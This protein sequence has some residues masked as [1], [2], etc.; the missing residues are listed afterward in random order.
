MINNFVILF[1]LSTMLQFFGCLGVFLLGIILIAVAFLG[2]LIDSIL[3]FLG[4]KKRGS[5][6]SSGFGYGPAGYGTGASGRSTAN[7]QSQQG[8]QYRDAG[9]TS[10]RHN[11]QPT[12]GKQKRKIFEKDESEYVDFEEI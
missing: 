9:S 1:P 5:R 7:R 10:S 11:E 3:V 4:L 8:T 2:N 12:R 6:P